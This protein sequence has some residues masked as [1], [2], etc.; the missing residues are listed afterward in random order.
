MQKKKN[1]CPE[2]GKKINT[3]DLFCLE[4]G[5]SIRSQEIESGENRVVEP[6]KSSPK[7]NNSQVE[8]KTIIEEKSS[9]GI[10][11]QESPIG[12]KTISCKK[13][14]RELLLNDE[15]CMDCGTRVEAT[16]N[17]GSNPTSKKKKILCKVCGKKLKRTDLF[18]LNC[19]S[20]APQIPNSGGSKNV[21]KKILTYIF[22]FLILALLLTAVSYFGRDVFNN[23]SDDSNNNDNLL[24]SENEILETSNQI[25]DNYDEVTD[26]P[27]SETAVKSDDEPSHEPTIEPTPAPT[28]EN[29]E[30]FNNLSSG[31]FVAEYGS[32]I[33]Y[34][35][36]NHGG[37]V[38]AEKPLEFVELI[39]AC[40]AK[41]LLVYD[42]YVF[43]IDIS[44]NNSVKKVSIDS[45]EVEVIHDNHIINA[46]IVYRSNIYMAAEDKLYKKTLESSELTEVYS[47]SVQSLN[48][49][50]EY[51]YFNDGA[52]KKLI[53]YNINTKEMIPIYDGNVSYINIHNNRIFFCDSK[54]TSKVSSVDV[55]GERYITH[56]SHSVSFMN[57]HNDRIYYKNIRDKKMYSMDL[58]GEVAYQESSRDTQG[59]CSV[60]GNIYYIAPDISN[61]LYVNYLPRIENDAN[62][63]PIWVSTSSS[64][65]ETADKRYHSS[66]MLDGKIET[67]WQTTDMASGGVGEYVD[68]HLINGEKVKVKGIRLINGA[69]TNR[70]LYYRCNRL[71][72][73]IISTEGRG[74]IDFMAEDDKRSA[75]E[76]YFEEPIETGRLRLTVSSVHNGNS[77]T[78]KGQ[79]Y[80]NLVIPELTLLY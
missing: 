43:F 52:L 31:G 48:C 33:I 8:E 65:K 19:G 14:G 6:A 55:F 22:L 54:K 3:K 21:S 1:V 41:N 53:K 5:A 56:S 4:C 24:N 28:I 57:I 58:G 59:I 61:N 78:Y 50:D 63:K 79:V 20:E 10:I 38:K 17:N 29:V 49:L 23:L 40:N 27:L 13:C 11:S 30:N 37:I 7:S 73:F 16:K 18:C 39:Y 15:F 26:E 47:G 80:N 44:D 74:N 25:S 35:D 45:K 66:K 68:L 71:G 64:Y 46:F 12:D 2:C 42:G 9:S 77:S 51:L 69:A 60:L 72:G 32:S 67:N 62:L 75:Q 34:Y 36:I 76:F 70:S